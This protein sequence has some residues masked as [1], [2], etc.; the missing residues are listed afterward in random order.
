MKICKKLWAVAAS[1][2][3]YTRHTLLML[4]IVFHHSLYIY[5]LL[6][7]QHNGSFSPKSL[8]P[9]WLSR[10]FSESTGYS[11]S[12]NNVPP[13]LSSNSRG[14]GTMDTGPSFPILQWQKC[15]ICFPECSSGIGPQLPTIVTHFRAHPIIGF[16]PFLNYLH[17]F[18]C[19]SSDHLPYKIL[20]IKSFS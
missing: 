3:K 6:W 15:D 20:T 12:F 7:V 9:P 17:F 19:A 16:L 14:R 18:T 2:N 11:T 10:A 4:L 5:L 8:P 1:F 13:G